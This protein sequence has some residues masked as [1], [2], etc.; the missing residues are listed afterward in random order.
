M[1]SGRELL[2]KKAVLYFAPEELLQK[3][4]E[5]NQLP[6]QVGV[7]L[8]SEIIELEQF[9]DRT[10]CAYCGKDFPLDDR[11]ATQ[12]SAHIRECPEHPL[13]AFVELANEVVKEYPD[14][15]DWRD[16]IGKIQGMARKALGG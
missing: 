9:S 3:A 6:N 2:K 5:V 7:Y 8:Q 11:A 1:E 4:E 10:Y 15:A 14:A 13:R 16:A 12:V